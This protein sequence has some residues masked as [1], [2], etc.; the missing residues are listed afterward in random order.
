MWTN[1]ICFVS[2]CCEAEEMLHFVMTLCLY[3]ALL[4]REN[5]RKERTL[6]VVCKIKK[7]K[8]KGHPMF[9]YLNKTIRIFKCKKEIH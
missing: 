2:V 9:V 3:I 4:R 8:M 6:P 7:Y 1:V 5:E